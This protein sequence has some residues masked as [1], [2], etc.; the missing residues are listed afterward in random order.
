M[1]PRVGYAALGLSLGV[2]GVAPATEGTR[3]FVPHDLQRTVFPRQAVGT[4]KT[5]RQVSLGHMMRTVDSAIG[6]VAP[7]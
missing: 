7:R 2:V 3:I 6:V 1:N 5:L 4:A